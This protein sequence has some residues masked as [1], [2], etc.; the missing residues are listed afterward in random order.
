MDIELNKDERIDDLQFNEL[1]IIQNKNK[2]CFGFD[3][4][5]LANF[6]TDIKENSD[7][8]DLGTGTRRYCYFVMW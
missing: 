2:F 5:L 6:A 7:V 4:V 8:L 1:K 3:A